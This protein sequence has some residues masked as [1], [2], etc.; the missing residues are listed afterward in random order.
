MVRDAAASRKRSGRLITTV[1]TAW[2]GASPA[3]YDA[4]MV[5][6]SAC[7][8]CAAL[9]L[10]LV[11]GLGL[12][13]CAARQPSAGS[14]AD[15]HSAAASADAPIAS[16]PA[17][18]EP[19]PSPAPA[20]APIAASSL[21]AVL[22]DLTGGQASLGRQAQLGALLALR[23]AVG[24]Q[25]NSADA[26]FL[27]ADTAS[28][29]AAAAERAQEAAASRAYGI[30]FTD[31]DIAL[32]GVP[33]FIAAG[34][35]F[36]V[37]GATD[38][39]LPGRCG[40]GTLLACFGDDA[41]AIAGAEFAAERFGR[42]A[43]VV[44]DSR[45]DYC[46]TLS[47]HF[48]S[49]LGAALGGSAVAEFDIAA[50]AIPAIPPHLVELAEGIDFVYLAL[51]PED[52]PAAI[53]AVRSALP[54]TPIV[55]GDSLDFDGLLQL[56]G[57]PTDGVWFTT[58]AWLGQGAEPAAAAFAAAFVRA[59]GAEPTA[60]AALG[61]DAARLALDARLRAGSDSPEAIA[62]ALLSTVEFRGVTGRMNFA[63]G[64][65]PRKDVWVVGIV[66]GTRVLGER[67]AAPA[68]P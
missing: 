42:R 7:L 29:P 67:R 4:S 45:V 61:Y 66:S 65:V 20:P 23:E 64:P 68:R 16:Q 17:G 28:S 56:N 30:G 54:Q 26:G 52:V 38:P 18:A 60:F 2:V 62:A 9:V 51:A 10:G 1:V 49:H 21:P 19:A 3:S 5:A 31:S 22:C 63:A 6:R 27:V 12:S 15:P 58:H 11:L 44:F 33:K 36:V 25:G 57:L 34:R 32:A 40:G 47:G 24:A 13:A 14:P 48:R 59:H 53:H 55:G 35:P 41:Q 37:I 8:A 39:S 43:A 46:R 50:V